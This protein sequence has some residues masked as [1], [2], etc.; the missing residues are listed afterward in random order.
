MHDYTKLCDIIEKRFKET[1]DQ[2]LKKIP[3]IWSFDIT[4]KKNIHILCQATM[5]LTF[6]LWLPK[7]FLSPSEGLSQMGKDSLKMCRSTHKARN[8]L[9]EVKVTLIFEKRKW[10]DRESHWE[11]EK[12]VK[13]ICRESHWWDDWGPEKWLVAE[14]D[15]EMKKWIDNRGQKQTNKPMRQAEA[16]DKG[17]GGGGG[18]ICQC[19]S[20]GDESDGWP[21]RD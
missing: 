3:S 17:K 13:T 5:T 18:F 10:T 20:A 1:S 15:Q 14:H 2:K 21:P 7:S 6:D 9:R 19:V 16:E 12:Q 11:T 4:F 8:V